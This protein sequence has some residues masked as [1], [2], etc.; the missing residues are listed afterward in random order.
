MLLDSV[1]DLTPERHSDRED[2]QVMDNRAFNDSDW[3]GELLKDDKRWGYGVPPTGN[4]SFVWVRPVVD[5]TAHENP[6]FVTCPKRVRHA[7]I[8]YPRI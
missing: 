8:G 1:R 2:D 3:R 4:G 5:R 6:R 7:T